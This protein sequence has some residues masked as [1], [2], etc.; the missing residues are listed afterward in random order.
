[1]SNIKTLR[2][3]LV[4]YLT[5]QGWEIDHTISSENVELWRNKQL[6]DSIQIPSQIGLEHHRA[7]KTIDEAFV[8]IT[9]ITGVRKDDILSSN[10][11]PVD[12]IHFRAIGSAIEHGKVNIRT[13]HIIENAIYS[14]FNHAAKAFI[15]VKKGK[16]KAQD[17]YLDSVNALAP[18]GGSFI[19]NYEVELGTD[20]EAFQDTESLQRYINHH[21]ANALNTLH[22]ENVEDL[23]LADLFARKLNESLCSDFIK[24]F[25][26]DVEELECSFDWSDRE[27]SPDLTIKTIRFDRSHKEKAEK[28]RKKF[29]S[30]RSKRLSNASAKLSRIEIKDTIAAVKLKLLLE[31][32]ERTFDAQIDLEEAQ[33]LMRIYGEDIEQP[34]MIDAT[35]WIEKSSSRHDYHLTDITIRTESGQ[36]IS[37]LDTN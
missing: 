25:A 36:N 26:K 4:A 15:Q 2:S 13:S 22:K 28:I 23:S 24:M 8:D 10:S 6:N 21:L 3:K 1:M 31:G 12:E 16:K 20:E 30:S 18:G 17:T 34:V 32:K 19:Y 11:T 29:R 14:L 27:V 35:A 9:D 7:Q 33:K 37:L 5:G